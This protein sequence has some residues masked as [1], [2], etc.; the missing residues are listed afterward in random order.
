MNVDMQINFLRNIIP[1][2]KQE[3]DEFHLKQTD[4]PY[5][6]YLNNGYFDGTDALVLHCMIRHFKLRKIIECGSGF[7][8]RVSAKASLLNG[9]TE[10]ISIEPYPSEILKKGFP[11]LARLYQEKIEDIDI[12]LFKQLKKGDILFIDTSHVVKIGG[13]VNKIYL[14]II[15]ILNEGVLVHIHDIF[16]QGNIRKDRFLNYVVFGL[17]NICCKLFYLL[18]LNLRL[19][20][21]IVT[22]DGNSFQRC[23]RLSLNRRSGVVA[24]FG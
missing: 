22:W 11:G 17:N 24:V 20:F 19:F 5:E 6:F 23:G 10:L 9:N 4:I 2:F 18:I 13:D 3:Y 21:V 7:S 14:E 12:N 15:P 8:T 16:S 1:Q